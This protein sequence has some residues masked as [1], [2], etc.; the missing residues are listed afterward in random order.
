MKKFVLYF[1]LLLTIPATAQSSLFGKESQH[2]SPPPV[3]QPNKP[4]ID[5]GQPIN[6]NNRNGIEK[7]G[8]N[9]RD[10]EEI[11]RVIS[12]ENFDETRLNTA[13]RMIN[14]NPMSTRQIVDICKLFT[15]EANRLEFAKYAYIH[16]VDPNKYFLVNEVFTFDSS[17][18]ELDEY[19][20]H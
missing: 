1:L 17:K 8:M 12:K 10:Y 18:E 3:G 15:F 6:H 13:K 16:C 11:V 4:L 2:S 20:R 5:A 9:P 7:T 19:I 14:I